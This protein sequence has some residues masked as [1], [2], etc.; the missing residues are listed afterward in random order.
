MNFDPAN[1]EGTYSLDLE[2]SFNQIVL[3]CLLAAAE[4]SVIRSENA[5]EIK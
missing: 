5:F 1:P 4:K 3:Q 2:E